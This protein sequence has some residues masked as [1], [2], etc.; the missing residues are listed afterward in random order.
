MIE[1]NPTPLEDDESDKPTAPPPLPSQFGHTE[2][3][4]AEPRYSPVRQEME[5]ELKK[6]GIGLCAIGGL[7]V[8]LSGFLDPVWGVILIVLG[9]L[10]FVVRKCGMFIV[11]GCVLLLAGIM[12]LTSGG[13]GGSMWAVFGIFQVLWGL[14]E[15]QRFGKFRKMLAAERQTRSQFQ[16]AY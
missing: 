8:L 13:S 1:F 10:S 3:M 15:F 9:G 14:Q 16:T 4:S 7:S 6:W 5:A 2:N 12:N 11:F